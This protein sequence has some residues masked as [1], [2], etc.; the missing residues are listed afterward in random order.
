M[1]KEP[2]EVSQKVDVIDFNLT[3]LKCRVQLI[4]QFAKNTQWSA[5]PKHGCVKE[6]GTYREA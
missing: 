2:V 4:H 6:T 5:M 1:T 3:R